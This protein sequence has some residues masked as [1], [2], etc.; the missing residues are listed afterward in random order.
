MIEHRLLENL[1]DEEVI[2][3]TV[4][5]EY[6]NIYLDP[7]KC[8]LCYDTGG[9]GLVSLIHYYR[10]ERVTH[11]ESSDWSSSHKSSPLIGRYRI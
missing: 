9:A 11:S 7:G 4:Y 10:Q 1:D 8:L 3:I 6:S 2:V 5:K